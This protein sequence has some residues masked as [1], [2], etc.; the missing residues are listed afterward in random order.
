MPSVRF[1]VAFLGL[2]VWF[3]SQNCFASHDDPTVGADSTQGDDKL[4]QQVE[5][6]IARVFPALVRIQVVWVDYGGGREQK[7]EASGSGVI[8]SDEG[9]VVTNHHVA[10][11]ASRITV[12]LA[13]R[14]EIPASLVGTDPLADIAVLKLDLA[15][16]KDTSKP[17]PVAEFGNPEELHVGDRVLAMGSPMALSQSVTMGIVSNMSMI[18]PDRLMGDFQLD[19]ENVGMLVKWIGHDAQIFPGN[20]G[21]PL[22]NLKGQVVGINEIGVGLGGAIPGDLAKRSVDEIVKNGSVKRSWLGVELQPLLK[23]MTEDRGV[24]VA[25]VID[26]SPAAKAGLRPGD[27]LVSFDSRPVFARFREQLPLVNRQ[28]LDLPIGSTVKAVV[29]RGAEDVTLQ[30]TTDAREA[31]RGKQAELKSWGITGS[32]ITTP[33]AKELR[34]EPKSGVLISSTRAGGAAGEAKPAI[35]DGDVIVEVGGR[36][37]KS[38]DDLISITHDLTAGKDDKVPVLVGYERRG[39][40]TL[41]VVSLGPDPEHR[42]TEVKKAWFPAAYQVLTT[43]LADALGISGKSGIR[44][45]QV[46]PGTT[47]EAAGIKVGDIITDIDGDRIPAS[48]PED[49]QV[50]PHMIRQRK[51]GS[52]VTLSV[53]RGNEELKIDVQLPARPP[54]ANELAS[55]KDQAFEFTVREPLFRERVDNRWPADVKGVVIGS[56]EPGGWAA[57][58]GVHTGD[59][60]QKVDDKAIESVADVKAI[61]QEITR[62]RAAHVVFQ[63]RR[64][65]HTLFIEIEPAWP[66]RP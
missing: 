62:R 23:G 32:E 49:L 3:T 1:S 48:Q 29:K 41:T 61:M 9:H 19:G 27:V 12:T 65:I 60:L 26:G 35:V 7:Y 24:L 14:E 20:S 17:I 45:T 11:R 25:G 63:V 56:V 66:A 59:L 51:I 42:V 6:S 4:R 2:V 18:M 44:I 39:E 31:A 15:A 5:Q 50:F 40:R 57:F 53:V 22:V 46:F 37:V 16:R 43:P 36:P 64:G 13:S 33:M 54:E 34:R 28:I 58:A 10:G 38:I 21:G 55:S 30:I 8:I 47:V 52:K